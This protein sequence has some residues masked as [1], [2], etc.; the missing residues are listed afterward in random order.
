MEKL[1]KAQLDEIEELNILEANLREEMKYA[2]WESQRLDQERIYKKQQDASYMENL[3]KQM[4]EEL[5]KHFPDCSDTQISDMASG[6]IT[7]ELWWFASEYGED[8]EPYFDLGAW[9]DR[10]EDESLK[11]EYL[12]YL[13]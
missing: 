2:A 12:E 9:S 8:V 3:E 11:K 1:T 4:K 5:R 10:F 13:D 6:D 7:S